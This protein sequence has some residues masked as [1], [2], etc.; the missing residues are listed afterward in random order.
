MLMLKY[1]FYNNSTW[2]QIGHKV[3]MLGGERNTIHF[4]LGKTIEISSLDKKPI[5]LMPA[6]GF[7]PTTSQSLSGGIRPRLAQRLNH[8][9][10]GDCCGCYSNVLQVTPRFFMWRKSK[11]Q[12]EN[13]NLEFDEANL[14]SK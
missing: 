12:T 14:D 8:S 7:E 10:T 5:L 4:R 3:I 2:L 1:L 9:A 6:V 11:H 13:L